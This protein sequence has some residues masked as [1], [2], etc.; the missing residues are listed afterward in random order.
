[1]MVQ[2]A[3]LV[4]LTKCEAI[5]ELLES[6]CDKFSLLLGFIM[7]STGGLDKNHL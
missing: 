2:N 7:K 3:G 6:I 5:P 4:P 1:M